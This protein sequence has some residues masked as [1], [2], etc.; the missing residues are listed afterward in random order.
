MW[1]PHTDQNNY[2]VAFNETYL[3]RVLNITQPMEQGFPW[4]VSQDL[5]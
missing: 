5:A 4:T 3:I 2:V 1:N